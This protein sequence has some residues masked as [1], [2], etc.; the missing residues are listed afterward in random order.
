MELERT[1]HLDNNDH[2]LS[3][4]LNNE[5]G[6]DWN[7]FHRAEDDSIVDFVDMKTKENIA[8]VEYDNAKLTYKVYIKS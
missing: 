2:A 3:D 1:P 6:L 7:Y 4:W 8:R 5:S